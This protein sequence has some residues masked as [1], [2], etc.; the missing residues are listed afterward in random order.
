M[1]ILHKSHVQPARPGGVTDTEWQPISDDCSSWS[2][3]RCSQVSP[4]SRVTRAG[5][6]H[7]LGPRPPQRP[8]NAVPTSASCMPTV[9]APHSCIARFTTLVFCTFCV[10]GTCCH[11]SKGKMYGLN[12]GASHLIDLLLGDRILPLRDVLCYLGLF[13]LHCVDV[14]L[15]VHVHNLFNSSLLDPV[16]RYSLRL[17]FACSRLAARFSKL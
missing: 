10:I 12:A 5:H 6:H 17:V 4:V 3:V 14:V 13:H 9:S 11:V 7:V 1:L 15:G 8:Q 2:P 16:L